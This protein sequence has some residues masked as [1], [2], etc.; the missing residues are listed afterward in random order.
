MQL[1]SYSHLY[2]HMDAMRFGRCANPDP[3]ARIFRVTLLTNPLHNGG[4]FK[5]IEGHPRCPPI[6]IYLIFMVLD[7]GLNTPVQTNP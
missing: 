4:Q 5:S 3:V 2:K 1:A 6:P 7:L